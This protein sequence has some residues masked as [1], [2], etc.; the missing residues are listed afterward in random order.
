MNQEVRGMKSVEWSGLR[1]VGDPGGL[2]GMVG[3]MLGAV[4]GEYPLG[5]LIEVQAGGEA[6]A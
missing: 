1:A 3:R 2:P 5:T 4:G 6:E